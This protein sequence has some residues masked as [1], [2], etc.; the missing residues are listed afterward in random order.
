MELHL[1]GRFIGAEEAFELGMLNAVVDENDLLIK[2]RE[3]MNQIIAHP[4]GAV[5]GV[6]H[7]VN[8][9]FQSGTDGFEKEIEEF[10][11]CFNYEDFKEG[12]AAFS[13]KRKPLFK[14]R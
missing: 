7:A 5:S 11:K 1:T 6:I 9:Y 12:V 2:C 13:E 8:A 14:G 4:P 3:L 10:G